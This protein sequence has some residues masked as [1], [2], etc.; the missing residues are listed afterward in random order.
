MST[1]RQAAGQHPGFQGLENQGGKFPMFGKPPAIFSNV[2][3]N[4]WKIFQCL[5]KCG[6]AALAAGLMLPALPAAAQP[7]D[8]AV[9][10]ESLPFVNPLRVQADGAAPAADFVRLQGQWINPLTRR[11]AGNA[12]A[13]LRAASAP[14][15][16]SLRLVQLAGKLDAATQ[17]RFRK[18]G[19][20]VCGYLPVNTYIVRIPAA[21]MAVAQALRGVRWTGNY[22]AE[23]RLADKLRQRLAHTPADAE[24]AARLFFAPG[25]DPAACR[26]AAAALANVDQVYA[27]A[28]GPVLEVRAPAGTIPALAAL[29]NLLIMVDAPRPRLM[30]NIAADIIHDRPMRDDYGYYGSN[31]IVCVADSGLDVCSN[32]TTYVH[33]DFQDGAGTA[34]IVGLQDFVGDGCHD[35]ISGHGTHVAGSVLGNGYLSGADPVNN[36]FPTGAYAGMAP[37]ARLYFQALG[38]T[39]NPDAIYP[40]SNLNN[41]FRP[42]FTN[43]ARIHQNSWGSSLAGDYNTQA[44]EVDEFAFHNPGMLICY[45]AGN[46]GIDGNSDGVVDLQSMGAPGTAKNCLTVGASENLRTNF[47][48]SY[49]ASWPADYPAEPIFSDPKAN[50]TNGMAAFSSR[51][52]CS[53]GR[54][55][56]DVVAPGTYVG[57]TRT[58]A[59]PVTTS[60]LWGNISGNTN[61]CWSG[62]T[63]MSTPL[64]SGAAAILRDY[65]R[66]MYGLTNEPGALLKALL[67][68]GAADMDPGQYGTGATREMSAVPNNVEGWGRV[69]LASSLYG[70]TNYAMKFYDG[71]SAAISQEIGFQTNFELAVFNTGFALRVHLAWDDFPGSIYTIDSTFSFLGGGG[72]VNDLDLLVTDPQG[73]THRARA[74]NPSANLF[75]YTNN[76]SRSWF[77]TEGLFQAELCVAPEVPFDLFALEQLVQDTN[78]VGGDIATYVWAATDT[79]GPPREV[80]FVQTNTVGGGGGLSVMTIPASVTIT[81][82]YFYIGAEQMANHNIRQPMDPGTTTRKYRKTSGAWSV[83]T[84]GDLWM[85]AYGMAVTN[86]RANNLE[87]VVIDQPN[88]G[89]Y[90]VAVSGACVPR[91]PQ[92]FAVAYSG[93]IELGA[94]AVWPASETNDMDFTAA[95]GSLAGAQNYLLDVA[96]NSSFGAAYF[97]PAF[98]NRAVSSTAIMV[99]GL[100]ANAVYYYRVRGNSPWSTSP[101]SGY[102]AVTTMTPTLVVLAGF[103]VREENGRVVVCWE[104]ASEIDTLGF[105]VYRLNAGEWVK[106]NQAMIA[107]QGWPQ[108][109]QGA[110]YCQADDGAAPGASAVYKLVEWETGGDQNTYGPFRHDPRQVQLKSIRPAPQGFILSWSSAEA[111]AFDL[112]KTHDL[113]RGFQPY[114]PGIPA[115]PPENVYTDEVDVGGATFYQLQLRPGAAP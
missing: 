5:E 39:T 23:F 59:I 25:T 13:D 103:D 40:P 14:V 51:G 12:A 101:Y 47:G 68:N 54:L 35:P 111:E 110:Q 90:T 41:L 105:D 108:G 18:E 58:H 53:D 36:S 7:V 83:A 91:R 84:G 96:S 57:S 77:L 74:L 63:S 30:N 112:Y 28:G 81:T 97:V 113:Q 93:G 56:P 49:G 50:W 104:T 114:A 16:D 80:L 52:P 2:W 31:E 24:V 19:W 102:M 48:S 60:V 95:W 32:S 27:D 94:P 88:T 115:T 10:V 76:A 87:G 75:Y 78:T 64:T 45:S 72:L 65:L 89:V 70:P 86:D 34:R 106:V 38:N 61:Y 69:N 17:A 66:Q 11:T 43:G 100:A 92:G 44:R 85:H 21:R 62:G 67:V 8:V 107:A 4:G 20:I 3:K 26:A 42:A 98:S 73:G 29:D 82:R 55:K 37:K 22:A 46:D 79:G 109:G 33:A 6:V 99:T 15:A 9:Q 71:W 1:A